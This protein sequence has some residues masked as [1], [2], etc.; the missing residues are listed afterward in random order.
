[1]MKPLALCL[2]CC[3]PIWAQQLTIDP[4][5]PQAPLIKR[6]YLPAEVPP[7]RLNNGSHLAEKIRGGNLYLTAQDAV[8]LA[9][10]NNI[11][12]EV[13][14][15]NPLLLAWRLERSQAGGA[16]PGVPSASS[17]ASAN[18]AG[19][20][21]LGS[22]Q[23]AGITGGN[24]GTVRNNN[25]STV[26]Q[27]GPVTQTLDPV[28]QESTSFSHR[29]LPQSNATGSATNVIVQDSRS[30]SGSIQQGF[31]TGGSLTMSYSQRYLNENSPTNVLN[32]SVAPGLSF[33]FT[34]NLL[35]GFGKA[36]GAR[37]ITVAKMNL[38]T[39]DLT[40][41][42]QVSR[43]TATVLNAY[44]TLAGDFDDVKSK[45]GALD[46]SRTFL[47]ETSRRLELGS[48]AQLD[49]TTAQNQVAVATQGFISAQLA[50][51]QQEVLLKNLIS[52]TGLA[53]PALA[54]AH[55]VPLDKITIPASEELPPLSELVKKTFAMRTDLQS[56][57]ASLN[58]SEVSALGTR[59]GLLPSLQISL[60]RSTSGL[61]GTPRI[62]RGVT[63]DPRFNGGLGTALG[64]VFA[65][66]FATQSAGLGGRISLE[67]RQAQADYGIDQL[68]MRQQQ[69]AAAK[70]SNQAQ[71]DVMNA[72]VA[73]RQARVRYD[74]AAQNRILQQ[75]L[76]DAEQ[77][78]FAAGESTTY[79]VRQQLRD[80]TNAQ[81]TELQ[82]LVTYQNAR[83]NLDQ[84]TGMIIE[85]NKISIA[86][87]AK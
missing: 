33:A 16:L 5:R 85:N 82:S 27:I 28:V 15:Y 43:V 73:L 11:D 50:L 44:Y 37:N 69:L 23:A 49:V 87:V 65:Q 54:N 64:Q 36:V 63:A 70:E 51:A 84:T 7:V 67:N 19:Q 71:V 62:V 81:G 42:T 12:I 31:V 57:Q 59:N 20:G 1:M 30:Y 41:R 17:Q 35:N 25:N 68:S 14:R 47:S 60:N 80:F 61:A 18:T 38:T 66:D 86:T 77:K 9:L 32:P 72:I 46:T 75:K 6:P 55:I 29:S 4:I 76:Y 56:T 10:E 58:A 79:N 39:S 2:A 34:H 22:Q 40:F 48:T 3:M 83:T 21:V 78:K 52:R 74:A 26:T 24:T 8:L 45:Q 13:A 53:D